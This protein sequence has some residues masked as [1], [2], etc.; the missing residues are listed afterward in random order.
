MTASG[1]TALVLS[2]GLATPSRRMVRLLPVTQTEKGRHSTRP[3]LVP[4]L[5]HGPRRQ[6]EL[7][8]RPRRDSGVRLASPVEPL[9]K[10]RG[11]RPRLVVAYRHGRQEAPGSADRKAIP[12]L[13]AS[14]TDRRTEEAFGRHGNAGAVSHQAGNRRVPGAAEKNK[15]RPLCYRKLGRNYATASC[16]GR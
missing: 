8:C 15:T 12:A 10:I 1:P 2:N 16:R 9:Q 13:F 3:K 6:I 7:S 5:L 4:P 14:A 11:L